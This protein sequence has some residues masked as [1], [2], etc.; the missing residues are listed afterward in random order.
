[1]KTRTKLKT[2][3]FLLAAATNMTYASESCVPPA[4]GQTP[5][6]V[7]EC[8]QKGLDKQQ[9]QISEL[10]AEN[11]A[12][13][14]KIQALQKQLV[15]Q[16]KEL[17]ERLTL[18]SIYRDDKNVIKF[19]DA[20]GTKHTL[21]LGDGKKQLQNEWIAY[22]PGNNKKDA[23]LYFNLNGS[24]SIACTLL[25]DEDDSLRSGFYFA[26]DG[27]NDVES[28][29]GKKGIHTFA[30]SREG[31]ASYVTGGWATHKILCVK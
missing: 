16:K 20:K 6:D 27:G 11:Q 3:L 10:K 15:V 4:K 2:A 31:V 8:L 14:D 17:D 5:L 21:D 24:P 25:H 1:M 29:W 19:V 23:I 28:I 13:Q 30:L 26:T 9:Q 7:L 12:Q 18:M 22:R